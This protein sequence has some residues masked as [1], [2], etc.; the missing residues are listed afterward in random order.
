MQKNDIE[1]GMVAPAYSTSTWEDLSEG[2]KPAGVT[3]E[4]PVSNQGQETEEEEGEG[5]ETVVAVVSLL[6]TIYKN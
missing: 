1:L 2:S 3:W 5:E 4:Q 6:N